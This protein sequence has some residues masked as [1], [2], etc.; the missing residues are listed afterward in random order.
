MSGQPFYGKYRGTVLG[1]LD[2]L[3]IGRIQVMV[4][5]VSALLPSS[6]AMPCVPI[7]GVQM[8]SYFVPPIGGH[9]WVEFEQGDPDLPIWVGGFWG[10]TADVPAPALADGP[11]HASVVLQTTAQNAIVIRDLPGPAGGI[12][13]KSSGGATIVVNDTGI[14]I[15][16]G[17]GATFAMTGPTVTINDGALVV[18]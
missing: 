3:G 15:Q 14:H 4:P 11:A 12:V 6:W 16:N 2:P 5:D 7:A 18:T 1:N 8:G 9:V 17:K 10:T 13:L